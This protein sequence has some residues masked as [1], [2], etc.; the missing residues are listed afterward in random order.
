MKGAML[1]PATVT[2]TEEGF[3]VRFPDLPEAVT[4]V[5]READILDQAADCLA[6]AISA[7]IADREDIP[8][9][10]APQPG[11][12]LVSL[13]TLLAAK[14]LLWRTMRETGTRKADL[15]RALGWD[16]KQVDRLLSPRHASR[17]DQIDAAMKA[18]GKRLVLDVA[19][20]A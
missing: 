7:R 17:P 2:P 4:F 8:A 13:P 12:R 10:S 15:A 1:Y 16:Q 20:A 19:D 11:Q 14:I 3:T 18:L 5:D 9:P 6:E